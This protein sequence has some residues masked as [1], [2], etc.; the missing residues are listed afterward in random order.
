MKKLTCLIS[1]LLCVV[2]GGVYANWAYSESEDIQDTYKEL[3]LGLTESIQDGVNGEYVIETNASYIIDQKEGSDHVAELK[4]VSSNTEAPYLTVKFIPHDSAS[5]DI[6]EHGVP[7][8]IAFTTSAPF[9]YKIDGDGNYK[10]DGTET[11]VLKFKNEANGAFNSNVTWLEKL[12]DGTDKVEYFYVTFDA[13]DLL[14]QVSLTR[15]FVLDI[16]SEYA[17]FQQSL[18][19]AGSIIVKVTDGTN[20]L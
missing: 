18:L 5:V 19:R 14:E 13:E 20:I 11:A 1:L 8:E 2:I 4:V 15:E 9:I 10:A 7:T 3:S 12:E 17:A 6:K 16:R